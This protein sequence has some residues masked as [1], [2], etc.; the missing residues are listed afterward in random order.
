MQKL[1]EFF[2][3]NY[4]TRVISKYCVF[5]QGICK[6]NMLFMDD[7]NCWN[8]IALVMGEWMKEWV[9]N[10]MKWYWKGK[11]IVLRENQ[12]QYHHKSHTDTRKDWTWA[13]TVR[14]PWLTAKAMAWANLLQVEGLLYEPWNSI[15][16]QHAL[17]LL[18]HNICI[19]F[20]WIM[21]IMPGGWTHASPSTW[22]G[23]PSS[24]KRG[25]NLMICKVNHYN[26]HMYI[27][28]ELTKQ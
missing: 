16:I 25:M 14:G 4:N 10:T 2:T 15:L 22:T 8:Y 11:I 18:R 26:H 13:S 3:T 21:R 7:V 12:S 27:S 23:T 9:W 28:N 17:T 5:Q 24:P 1:S 20:L 19:R 6:F